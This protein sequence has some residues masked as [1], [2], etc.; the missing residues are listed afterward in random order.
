[1]FLKKALNQLS[2]HCTHNHKIQLKNTDSLNNIR[3]SPL[4]Y[5]L[6]VELK[7][8]KRYITENLDKGFIN[9]SQAPFVS[10]I[11]FVK[12]KDSSLRFCINYRKLNNLT[13][14]DRYLLPLISKTL[15]YIAKAKIF[16]KLDI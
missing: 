4:Y 9:T 10:L 2:P 7:K 12:K 5:Y 16:T 11:L 8:V 6:A 15:T 3:Y 1:V 13:C 14:K